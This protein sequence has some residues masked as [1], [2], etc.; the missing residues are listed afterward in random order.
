MEIKIHRVLVQFVIDALKKVF[1]ENLYTDKALEKIFKTNKILGA[2]D[3]SFIAE[4]CYDLVRYYRK[5]SFVVK[6]ET[7]WWKLI[8]AY[9]I[10]K[11]EELP[12]WKEFEALDKVEINERLVRADN[13]RVLRE[14]I[15]DWMDELG[16]MEL[17]EQW[18]SELSALNKVA[19]IVLRV[20]TLKISKAKIIDL[21]A[22]LK[23][24]CTESANHNDA[25]IIN[26][27]KNVFSTDLFKNGFFEVQDA[28]SQLVAE[29]LQL[30]PGMRVIDACAGAGG[31]SIHIAALMKNK[32]Q[33]ISMDIEDW[34]LQELR[35]RSSRNGIQ[36]IETRAITSTKVIKRMDQSADRLLLDVPCSGL[37]VLRRNPDAK[38]KLDLDFINRVRIIQS[39]LLDNYSRMVKIKGKMVYATCS[40]LPTEN[41]TQIFKFLKRN[42]SFELE[43]ERIISPAESG[44]DGFYMARMIRVS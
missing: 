9:L 16:V 27:R 36:I 17:G 29:F 8:G 37:G 26:G 19:P 2:R 31:K 39:D 5:F 1:E 34:K 43:E 20:N 32:G 41:Q 33:L 28:S 3:R 6:D 42:A 25:L 40:I 24:N 30:E 10:S 35:K 21:L 38:W 44:F 13:V 11:G 15:S 22:E 23:I 12:E 14:S 7:N 4:T 18:E